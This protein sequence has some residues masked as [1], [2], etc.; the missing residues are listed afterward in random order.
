MGF[1][2]KFLKD[3][4]V[5]SEV[6]DQIV[7]E[8]R[9]TV[10]G[11][12]DEL[13]SLRAEIESGKGIKKELDELKEKSQ[14]DASYKEK[15]DALKKEFTQ[16]KSDIAGEKVAA[17][18]TEAYRK[19]LKEAGISEKRIDSVIRLAKADGIL[20]ALELDGES[21]KNLEAVT[22]AVKANYGEYIESVKEVGANIPN[23]PAKTEPNTFKEMSLAD[24]MLYANE[25]PN[26]AS[27]ASF[28]KGE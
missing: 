6:I 19:V 8:H 26:D 14:A 18:K 4:G 2:R 3:L 11:L 17:T 24:K 16:Y 23:P 15:Y 28:L 5:D 27:V 7:T 13:D 1:T 22:D 25:H 10:D 21:L 9:G 12:K 20:D